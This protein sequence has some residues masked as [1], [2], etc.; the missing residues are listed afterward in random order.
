[1]LRQL[2]LA[3]L[4]FV[5]S[6]QAFALHNANAIFYPLPTQAKGTFIAAKKLFL[7]EK[8]GLWIHDVHG[9][10]LFYDGQTILPKSGSF[11]QTSAK[12]LAYHKGAFWTFIENE[13]IELIQIR[14]DV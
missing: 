14:N 6:Y 4:G 11:L 5:L 1:M 12:Q 3:L 13:S 9:R 7:G 10:V 2:A 8:G